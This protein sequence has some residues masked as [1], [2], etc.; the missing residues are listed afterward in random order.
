[1][2]R[3]VLIRQSG[4]GC[5]YS[6]GCGLDWRLIEAEDRAAVLAKLEYEAVHWSQDERPWFDEHEENEIFQA[7][8]FEVDCDLGEALLRPL[9]AWRKRWEAAKT[10]AEA[11][12]T[13]EAE[14]AEYERLKKKF[15]DG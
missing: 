8:L 6:I 12:T 11:A 13:T 1:M 14:R 7:W 2:K 3:F 9:P 10:A 15:G 4:E 5:D